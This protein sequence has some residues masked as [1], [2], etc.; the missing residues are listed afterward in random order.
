[1]CVESSDAHWSDCVTMCNACPV[2]CVE[3]SDAVMCTG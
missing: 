2:K 3:S 1:M